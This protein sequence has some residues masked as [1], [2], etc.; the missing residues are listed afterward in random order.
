MVSSMK[1]I[2]AS[3]SQERLAIVNEIFDSVEVLA[4]DIDESPLPGE[5]VEELVRRLSEWKGKAVA[6]REEGLIIAADT[7]ICFKEEP[8]GKANND[9]EAKSI[10][11]R[12]SGE[13][14]EVLT[15]T[16]VCFENREP[17]TDVSSATL[18]MKQWTGD[19]LKT[20]LQSGSWCGRAGAF[21]IIDPDCP[22]EI[23]KGD[24][25][26]VRGISSTFIE[27]MLL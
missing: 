13:C 24:L 5:S 11:E 17:V 25:N 4:A 15:A 8:I 3:R 9:Q 10:L 1:V 21:S 23:L 12:L 6:N 19:S 22:A 27:K 26:V 18:K 7:L 14:F 16:S 20:Y 2:L